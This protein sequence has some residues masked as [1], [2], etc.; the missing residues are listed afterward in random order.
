MFYSISSTKSAVP[1]QLTRLKPLRIDFCSFKR[2]ISFFKAAQPYY[3]RFR[4]C[5][6]NSLLSPDKE[7]HR[8]LLLEIH[9]ESEQV[10]KYVKICKHHP[11]TIDNNLEPLDTN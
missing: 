8:S 2:T 5:V 10:E 6:L 4:S 3:S 1:P 9:K 7:A 11:T